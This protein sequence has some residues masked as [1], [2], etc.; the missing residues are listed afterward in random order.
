[1]ILSFYTLANLTSVK[2]LCSSKDLIDIEEPD[3]VSKFGILLAF[4]Q[5]FVSF[6]I[7]RIY[8]LAPKNWSNLSLDFKALWVHRRGS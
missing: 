4:I 7:L 6:W 3:V 8:P 5:K 2:V 1:M